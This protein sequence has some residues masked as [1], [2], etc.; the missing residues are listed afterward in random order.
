MPAKIIRVFT[1]TNIWFSAFYGSENCQKI[2]KA[3]VEKKVQVVISSTVIR[4]LAKNIAKKLPSQ[5]ISLQTFLIDNPPEIFPDPEIL[6]KKLVNLVSEKD[7]KIFVSAY[8]AKVDYFVTG[9]IKDFN[10]KKLEKLTGIKI[11]T[12]KQAVDFLKL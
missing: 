12:P 6:T 3:H 2:V 5:T 4:E 11:L 8:K 7:L 10:V 1:D 9:N